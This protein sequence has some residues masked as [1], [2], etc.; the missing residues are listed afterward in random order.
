MIKK[1]LSHPR[2]RAH[3]KQGL[4]FC[5]CGVLGATLEF[6]TIALLVHN[7]QMDPKIAFIPSG[8][9][10][11][12]FVFFFN[13]YITFGSR[14][15]KDTGNQT[16]R[17]AM[18]YGMAFV[19]NYSIASGL[20]VLGSHVFA[21]TQEVTVAM[22]AKALAIGVTA[23]WNYFFSSTFVFKKGAGASPEFALSASV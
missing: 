16:M 3:A 17:F 9:A 15:K 4:K 18:V 10:S 11:L 21:A 2:V 19:I 8:L 22:G 5:V 23:F 6:S 12:V 20:Y 7:M 1:L 13:K 14:D